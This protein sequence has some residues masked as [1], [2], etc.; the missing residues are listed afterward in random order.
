MNRTITKTK[1]YA[2]V[3]V[4]VLV[5]APEIPPILYYNQAYVAV[6]GHWYIR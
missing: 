2:F 3:F 5:Y 6:V 4:I 1:P